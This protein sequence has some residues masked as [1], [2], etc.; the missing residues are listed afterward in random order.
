MNMYQPRYEDFSQICRFC[1]TQSTDLNPLFDADNVQLT[2][3]LGIMIDLC[4]GVKVSRIHNYLLSKSL[5][6]QS[7][8]FIWLFYR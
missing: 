1:V 6:I 5:C 3:T 2:K 4:L 8:R 7:N